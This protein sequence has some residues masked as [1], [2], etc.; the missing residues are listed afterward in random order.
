[1]N[2]KDIIYRQSAIDAVEKWFFDTTDLRQPKEVLCCVP[3]AQPENKELSAWQEDFRGYIKML[4]LPNDDYKGI[5][6]YIDEVPTEQ[7]TIEKRK[8]GYWKKVPGY[9]TPGGD[10][11]WACSECGKGI[12]VYGI[13][14]SSY[15][16]DVA[17]GQWVACPNCGAEM[18]GEIWTK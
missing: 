5:M 14:H 10:P 18:L 8:V 12:H 6:A 2:D 16:R 7:P 4:N 11:V 17:D 13:E 3:S 9:A 1:M 15:G